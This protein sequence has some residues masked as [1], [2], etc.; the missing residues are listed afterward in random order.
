M[1]DWNQLYDVIAAIARTWKLPG[2]AWG[3]ANPEGVMVEHFHGVLRQGIDRPVTADTVFCVASIA[4]VVVALAVLH[5]VETGQ[6]ELD[7]DVNDIIPELRLPDTSDP[8]TIGSLLAHRS[9][10]PDFTMRQYADLLAHPDWTL[11]QYLK[12]SSPWRN[13]PEQRSFRYSNFGYDLL[14]RIIERVTSTPFIDYMDTLLQR[15][16][17]TDSS[18]AKPEH[19]EQVAWPHLRIP[20]LTPSATYPYS[21]LDAPSSSLHT[22]VRDMLKLYG[23]MSSVISPAMF[24]T[25]TRVR[26]E[27]GYYPFY[28]GTGLGINIGRFADEP[29][30]SH[31]GMGFGFTAFYMIFPQRGVSAILMCNE[32]SYAHDQIYH[33]IASAITDQPVPLS[34]PSWIVGLADI[35]QKQGLT[36]MFDTARRWRDEHPDQYQVDRYDLINLTYQ[37]IVADRQDILRDFLAG[38]LTLYPDD[39]EALDLVRQFDV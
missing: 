18:F 7:D 20:A 12:N 39:A 31:G 5:L 11:E 32:E 28:G 16:D 25:M 34:Q 33:A 13:A 3:I 37:M 36:A 19:V 2:V 26:S 15:L 23:N 17:M 24:E 4:K 35:H 27:R 10:L 29:V 30:F 38:Y 14:G 9:G 8:I 21:N 22:T 6:L 1:N